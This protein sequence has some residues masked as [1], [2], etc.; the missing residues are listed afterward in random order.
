MS[1]ISGISD[2][3]VMR[4]SRRLRRARAKGYERQSF[5]DSWNRYLA[6]L[7]LLAPKGRNNVTTP[8]TPE[9]AAQAIPI[10]PSN[11][12][13]YVV[14]SLKAIKT[15]QGLN[16]ELLLRRGVLNDIK[17]RRAQ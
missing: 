9:F 2:K 1:R 5:E 4:F 12:P 11:V 3:S 6:P 17:A 15:K 10:T 8:R 7:P 14:T 13:G 16:D